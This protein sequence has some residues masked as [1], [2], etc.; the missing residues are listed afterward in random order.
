MSIAPVV[1]TTEVKADPERAFQLFTQDM[2]R[3]WPQ[4]MTIAKKPTVNVVIEPREGGRWYEEDADGGQTPW[5]KVLVWAPPER[6][7]LAWQIN[8][9]FAYDPQL[10][11][12]LELTFL[13]RKGGGTSVRLE[14]RNL[15]RLGVDA[16]RVAEQLRG[17][18]PG[19]VDNYTTY[20]TERL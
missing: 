18:W 7:L 17:G 3:W 5:G 9:Q 12:E 4:R 6:L 14:H 19:I 2:G 20:V 16:P 1:R 15:E 11:T 8:A 10:V 13:P